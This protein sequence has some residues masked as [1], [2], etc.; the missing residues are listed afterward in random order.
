MPEDSC[1]P[2]DVQTPTGRFAAGEDPV[3][4]EQILDGAKRIFMSTGFDAASMNDITREAGVSKSTIYVYFANKDELFAALME[5]EKARLAQSLQDILT[6][7]DDVED[8]LFRFGVGFATHVTSNDT[9]SAMRTMI[10]VAPRMPNLS[11]RFFRD[12]TLNVR[13]VLENFIE[14]QVERGA[15]ATD[16]ISLAARQFI[17]L[18]TGSFLKLRLFGSMRTPPPEDEIEHIVSAGVT[19]FMAGYGTKKSASATE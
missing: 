4:R 16:D 7:V 9:I 14:R 13:T 5:R 12:E 19:L 1:V 17:E 8:G 3:K 10:G 2:C 18:C 15:L 6:G 11:Q